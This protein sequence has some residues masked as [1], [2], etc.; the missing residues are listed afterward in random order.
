MLAGHEVEQSREEL[1]AD[2]ATL[3]GWV[4][5]HCEIAEHVRE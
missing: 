1:P 4:D 2:P 3:G 5:C